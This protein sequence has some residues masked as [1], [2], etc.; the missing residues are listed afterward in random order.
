VSARDRT[1]PI[2]R[3][4][5]EPAPHH[6]HVPFS[7]PVIV[8]SISNILCAAAFCA[9]LLFHSTDSDSAIAQRVASLE[10]DSKAMQESEKLRDERLQAID[11]K[12]T[13]IYHILL[14]ET[15][16]GK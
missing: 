8:L 13:D 11:G 1:V 10:A 9:S 14:Q 16:G 7:K 12:V 4:L 15:G 2:T 6:P 3:P 5:I